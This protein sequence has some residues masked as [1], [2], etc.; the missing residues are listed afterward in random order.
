MRRPLLFAVA[1]LVLLAGQIPIGSVAGAAGQPDPFSGRFRAAVQGGS[2][3]LVL[4][5]GG[6]TRY[7]GTLDGLRG[8]AF[9]IA[10]MIGTDGSLA[11]IAETTG[12]ALFVHIVPSPGGLQATFAEPDARQQPRLDTAYQVA[13][14]RI[15]AGAAAAERPAP[16]AGPGTFS[17]P[18][19]STAPA[20]SQAHLMQGWYCSFSASGGYSSSNRAY[21]DGRGSFRTQ[22][23]SYSSGQ[24]GTYFG[25]GAPDVGRYEV[26]ANQILL[27]F[28][29]GSTGVATVHNRGTGGMISEAMYEGKLYARGLC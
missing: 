1:L 20:P 18:T 17:A 9:R 7:E 15:G 26:R 22:S 27:R 24:S 3:T 12:G 19:P 6:G 25:S 16:A 10:A 28:P 13:F 8:A 2:L 5:H 14:T 29:D 23:E 11:G 21:F 4:Q